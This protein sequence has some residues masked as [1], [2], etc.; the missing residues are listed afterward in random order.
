MHA[1]TTLGISSSGTLSH[2]LGPMAPTSGPS[3]CRRDHS[4]G[5]SILGPAGAVLL[6]EGALWFAPGCWLLLLAEGSLG[7]IPCCGLLSL[8]E[9]APW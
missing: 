4:A 8:L 2:D 6:L 3:P 9:R 7:L 1:L 5:E